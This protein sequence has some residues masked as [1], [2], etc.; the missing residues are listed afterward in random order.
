MF[1]GFIKIKTHQDNFLDTSDD[2]KVA[3]FVQDVLGDNSTF[4]FFVI[5]KF[6]SI[7]S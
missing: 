5:Q 3:F 7:F 4:T 2:F 1:L 6:I